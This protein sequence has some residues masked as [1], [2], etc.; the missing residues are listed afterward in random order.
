MTFPSR[1]AVYMRTI[2]KHNQE[3]D[4][5][6]EVNHKKLQDET[7]HSIVR[8]RFL[9]NDDVFP[10][11]AG[12]MLDWYFMKLNA[13]PPQVP[14]HPI[15]KEDLTYIKKRM[16]FKKQCFD[17]KDQFDVKLN[18]Q[19]AIQYV[20]QH[21]HESVSTLSGSS[22]V[23]WIQCADRMDLNKLEEAKMLWLDLDLDS[24]YDKM[25]NEN[26]L[27]GSWLLRK[28]SLH[29]KIMPNACIFVFAYKMNEKN[30]D[31]TRMLWVDGVGIY[32]ISPHEPVTSFKAF[33]ESRPVDQREPKYPHLAA[34]I[35]SY[36]MYDLIRCSPPYFITP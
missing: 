23:K 21:A 35:S 33:W 4:L 7:Y 28:S 18:D 19:D 22:L 24:T 14:T 13:Q 25:I 9:Q 34:L 29:A 2:Q 8:I 26:V 1:E 20:L 17:F 11:D 36:A 6:D 30:I 12:I 31:Q 16:H 3:S 10:F 5:K 32:V 15:T 27:P